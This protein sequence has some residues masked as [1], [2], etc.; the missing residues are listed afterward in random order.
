MEAKESI[1]EKLRKIKALAENG[2]GGEM[3]AA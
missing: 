2:V 3:I 1:L